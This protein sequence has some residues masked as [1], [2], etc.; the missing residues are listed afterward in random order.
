MF[1]FPNVFWPITE[2]L[3]WKNS[4][5]T[6]REGAK[7]VRQ[8]ASRPRRFVSV[9]A[10]LNPAQ[11]EKL[12][13]AYNSKSEIDV[14]LPCDI[15]DLTDYDDNTVFFEN[16]DKNVYVRPGP[17]TSD[18]VGIA[19]KNEGDWSKTGV[20]LS[21]TSTSAFLSVTVPT[22]ATKISPWWSC[23]VEEVN[24]T[25]ASPNLLIVDVTFRIKRF[26]QLPFSPGLLR[27][28]TVFNRLADRTELQGE[29]LEVEA[30]DFEGVIKDFPRYSE[31]L[32]SFEILAKKPLDKL[33]FMVALHSVAGR[34]ISV[35]TST[36]R[37]IEGE[38]VGF[39]GSSISIDWRDSTVRWFDNEDRR[40]K[41]YNGQDLLLLNHS[42][43]IMSGNVE[44]ASFTVLAQEPFQEVSMLAFWVDPARLSSNS[45]VI[46]HS[47]PAISRSSF[48]M[49]TI[50][51]QNA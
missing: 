19:I 16:D 15:S 8:L 23:F 38:V 41:F 46:R 24:W 13:T 37:H 2:T 30:A 51:P 34:L 44:T 25:K 20:V 27:D 39:T 10:G 6:T 4:E 45:V 7:I 17:T 36:N 32:R 33:Y 28:T 35:D 40:I 5:F 14:I 42:A 31:S 3:E 47:S 50:R 9:R 22:F 1:T 21:E 11:L 43:S 12:L 29:L 48:S 26:L 49:E 18:S